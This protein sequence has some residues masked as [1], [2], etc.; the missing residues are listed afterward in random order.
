MSPS[1]ARAVATKATR[2]ASAGSETAKRLLP[3]RAPPR[4]NSD[5]TILRVLPRRPG[6][7]VRARAGLLALGSSY[8]PRL[9]GL[10]ASGSLAGFVPDY[11]DGVAAALNRLPWALLGTPGR[12]LAVAGADPDAL[13]HGTPGARGGVGRGSGWGRGWNSGG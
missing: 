7:L 1:V 13:R 5:E 4:M 2:P 10:A 12:E 3:L 8:S 11:S 6:V 9:P